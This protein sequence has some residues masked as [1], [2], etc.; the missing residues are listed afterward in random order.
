MGLRLGGVNF[1]PAEHKIFFHLLLYCVWYNQYAI[2]FGNWD[3]T[4]DN[5]PKKD[6]RE[7]ILKYV[8]RLY[9]ILFT[10]KKNKLEG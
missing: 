1:K 7:L 9:R 6:D 8:C 2:Q 5:F 4:V 3:C 10:I